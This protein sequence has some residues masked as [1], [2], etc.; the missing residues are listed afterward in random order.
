M[1]PFDVMKTTLAHSVGG[2]FVVQCCVVG[3]LGCCGYCLIFFV[4]VYLKAHE[5]ISIFKV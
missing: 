3:L 5:E 1:T 2:Q 4:F